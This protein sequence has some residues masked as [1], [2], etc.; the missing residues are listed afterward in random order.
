MS[1]A[2]TAMSTEVSSQK[3]LIIT[4]M[5][6]S[7]TSLVAHAFHRSGLYLGDDL[8]GAKP[9]NPHGHFESQAIVDFHQSFLLRKDVKRWWS[10]VDQNKIKKWSGSEEFLKAA[11]MI[12]QDGFAREQFGF[13]DPRT[14]F[15]LDG[16]LSILPQSYYLFVLRHP[17]ECVQSL[18]NRSYAKIKIKW[19]PFKA[20]RSYNLWDAMNKCILSFAKAH[21]DRTLVIDAR[22][23]LLN[24]TR[25]S[26]INAL[27]REQWGFDLDPISLQ[28]IYD[29][30]LVRSSDVSS[31]VSKIYEQRIQT[32]Q[33]FKDL[34]AMRI[35]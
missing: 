25:V 24:V 10:Q 3:S 1:G 4:G 20:E 30:A 31:R 22:A 21:P 33:L 16:W 26:K 17:T 35:T 2:Y 11:T 29:P 5:H 8:I 28:D 13:K 23:D 14:A 15:F 7:H 6:R 27:I 18:I 9:S 34:S 12:L 32:K 19:R